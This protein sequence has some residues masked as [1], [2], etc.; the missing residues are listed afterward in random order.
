MNSFSCSCDPILTVPTMTQHAQSLLLRLIILCQAGPSLTVGLAPP[1]QGTHSLCYDFTINSKPA[2]G[3]QWC[4]VQGQV[5]HKN[6]LSYDC[7]LDKV[8]S[9]SALGGKVNATITWE[10]QNTMLREMGDMLKQQLA[11]I[12]A[13]NGMG[14][15][16]ETLEGRMTCQHKSSGCTSGS[17]QF[18]F[19]GQMWLRFDSDKRSWTEVHPGSNWMKEKW[20]NDREVSEFLHKTSMGDCRTWLEKF[21]VEWKTEL[22]PTG[23]STTTPDRVS[24]ESTAS[25]LIPSVL[26]LILTCFIHLGLQ[27]FLTGAVGRMGRETWGSCVSNEDRKVNSQEPSLH[28]DW[29]FSF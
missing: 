15:A 27:I 3:Q 22:E 10:E 26:L 13:E 29:S 2:P 5:D 4:T 16:L 25:T 8:K 9:M 21:L 18:G 1:L 20:E 23:P 28:S 24:Q 19:N 12:K 14:R 6:F 11:D 17:W 7:G